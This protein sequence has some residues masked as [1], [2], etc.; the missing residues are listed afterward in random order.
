MTNRNLDLTLRIQAEG[1]DG[2]EKRVRGL[3]DE[4]QKTG[5]STGRASQQQGRLAKSTQQLGKTANTARGQQERLAGSVQNFRSSALKAAGV[6]GGTAG[7]V[8]GFRSFVTTAANFEQSMSRVQAVTGATGAELEQLANL[9]KQMGSTTQF[10]ASQAADGIEFLGRAGFETSEIL[11]ALPNILSL[12]EAGALD[13]GSAADITS[14]IM[15]AFGI[16]AERTAE[17][18]DALVQAAQS[19]NTNIQQLGA[20]MSTAGPIASSLGISTQDAAAAIGTLSNAG[21][22]GERAG[23]GLRSVLASLSNVTPNAAKALESLGLTA[24]EVNPQTNSLTEVVRKL[25]GANLDANRAFQIFGR[26]AAPAA[27]ALTSNAPGFEELAGQINNSEGAAASAAQTMRDNLTGAIKSLRSAMEGAILATNSE[28][29][30]TGSLQQL[31]LTMRD[32][33]VKN[34][35]TL[36]ARVTSSFTTIAGA[37]KFMAGSIQV[38]FNG[39]Q[40]AAAALLASV[41]NAAAN[42]AA[43]LSNVSFGDVSERFAQEAENL[44]A[45]SRQLR[46]EMRKNASELA[47]ASRNAREGLVQMGEGLASF[48]DKIA[49]PVLT[50]NQQLKRLTAEAPAAAGYVDELGNSLEGTA[51][52]ASNAARGFMTIEERLDAMERRALEVAEGTRAIGA[53][54]SGAE[55]EATAALERVEK[56]FEKLGITSSR[57]LRN[58]AAEAQTA[59]AAIRDSGTASAGDVERAFEAMASATLKAASAADEQGQRSV[60]ASLR[61][62][63]ETEAQRETV[64]ELIARYLE[65]GDRSEEAGKRAEASHRSAA[66]AA[67]AQATAV[68][69]ASGGPKS[70]TEQNALSTIDSRGQDDGGLGEPGSLPDLQAIESSILQ[71]TQTSG[72]S[73]E[74]RQALITQANAR[75]DNLI[76]EARTG[77]FRY[78]GGAE[79]YGRRQTEIIEDVRRQA[80]E[81]LGLS[82]GVQSDRDISRRFRPPSLEERQGGTP[83]REPSR[84][85]V[86]ININTERGPIQLQGSRDA[87]NQIEELLRGL[88]DARAVSAQGA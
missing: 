29:G 88:E 58:Q 68:S 11:S 19:A 64:D 33:V 56:A 73:Q 6:L 25:E 74:D 47:D 53:A 32:S 65:L 57:S 31:V 40:T 30:L 72:L 20:A 37:G 80:D 70:I 2:A 35:E 85:V 69:Q 79:R 86:D 24:A 28:S 60:A 1:F 27:L 51:A 8:A 38:A 44:R 18:S 13:L 49:K 5:D 50:L 14:N 46:D 78:Q 26:E 84:D 23:T 21:I 55:G 15:S 54:A 61:A 36:A 45:T 41:V 71:A 48:G 34:T 75:L 82:G 9:A 22:Q 66:N 12:A 16:E 81:I 52:S 87:A 76:K 77:K 42:A 62:K 3:R 59:Y 17:V 63:A 67:R 83:P 43:A 10:S 39:V 4:I 7:L